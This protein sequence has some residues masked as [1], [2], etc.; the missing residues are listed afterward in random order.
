MKDVWLSICIVLLLVGFFA[1]V[2]EH[3]PSKE[4]WESVGP[5]WDQM[6]NP[7]KYKE[8]TDEGK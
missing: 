1:I 8:C 7:C 3:N 2:I 5:A 4:Y 6:F